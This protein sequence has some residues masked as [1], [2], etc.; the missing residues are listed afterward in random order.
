MSFFGDAWDWVTGSSLSAN[1]AKTAALGYATR[2]LNDTTD[3]S[4]NDTSASSQGVVEDNGAR[5]QLNPDTQNKLPILYGEAYF[6]GYLTDAELSPDYKKM[7]YC[8]SLAELTGNKLDGSPSSYTFKN[9]YL[10]NNRVVFKPDGITVDL[11]ID[12]AGNEDISLRDLVKIYFYADTPLQP[13]GYSGSTPPSPSIM[14]GWTA[15]DNAMTGVMYAIIEV[16]Y[17]RDKNIVGLPNCLWHIDNSLTLPGD[18][19]NDYM[20]STVYGAGILPEEIDDSLI[21]LNAYG[22]AGFSFTDP[23]GAGQ[24]GPIDINGLINTNTNVLRNMQALVKCV[25]SWIGYDIHAGK[26]SVTINK[27]GTSIAS[28]DDSNIVDDINVS[29]TSL[30][31][32]YSATD[33]KYQNTDIK[34]KT[35][36]VK[37]DMPPAD[38]YQNE[39]G[40]RQQITL[41]Y[42]NKQS[43]ALK[44][45]LLQLKQSRIDK[46]ITFNSDYSY[47][48]L[49]AGQIID[50]T[51]ST[52]GYTN[53][54]FRI[55]TT[56]EVDGE[57]GQIE[58][59]F[60]CL[61]YND[62]VYDYDIQEYQIETDDGLLSIGS[63]GKPDAPLI[64]NNFK[65]V[66]PHILIT[67]K[68][69]S[70]VVDKMWFWVTRDT[71][72]ANDKDRIY[73]RI[74]SKIDTINPTFDE[75]ELV[76]LKYST[77]NTSDMYVK[78]SGSNSVVDGPLSDPSGLIQYIPQQVADTVSDVPV[79]MGDGIL[80]Q[81]GLLGLLKLI[82]YMMRGDQDP[83]G[84]GG[85]WDRIF[86]LF[87]D[88]TGVDIVQEAKDGNIG[89]PPGPHDL[90]SHTDVSTAGATPGDVLTYNGSTWIPDDSCCEGGG[91][92]PPPAEC[93]QLVAT[94]P[95]DDDTDATCI[96]NYSMSFSNVTEALL[97]GTGNVS[98]YKSDGT[99]VEAIPASGL[100]INGSTVDIP[101]AD[102]DQCTDYYILVDDC[103]ITNSMGCCSEAILLPTIWNFTTC[104][105]SNEDPGGP[106]PGP[107]PD[108]ITS[109]CA[110]G[111]DDDADRNAEL[112]S[113]GEG[114]PKCLE[115][116]K[117]CLEAWDEIYEPVMH[118]NYPVTATSG[119][120]ALLID[121]ST[122]KVL[123]ELGP[124]QVDQNC[125][126]RV[127][128]KLPVCVPDVNYEIKL[129]AGFVTN[130]AGDPS[131]EEIFPYNQPQSFGPSPVYEDDYL[132]NTPINDTTDPL[133]MEMT[134]NLLL[135]QG[136]MR[137]F[138]VGMDD[139]PDTLVQTVPASQAII[140]NENLI[141]I[142]TD[143][144]T[145]EE[146]VSLLTNIH[147][148]YN[149]PI[150]KNV[151]KYYLYKSPSNTSTGPGQLIQSFDVNTSF[152]ADMTSGI[153]SVGGNTVTLN[154]TVCL[155]YDSRYYIL[156]D[157]AAVISTCGRVWGGETSPVRHYFFTGFG[158]NMDSSN[159]EPA[160]E[161]NDIPTTIN[162]TGITMEFELGIQEGPGKTYIYKSDGTKVAEYEATDPAVTITNEEE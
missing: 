40:S 1:L 36:F 49:K 7:T 27:Q 70:G 152:E 144:Y 126:T 119:T 129:P 98:L 25:S 125:A 57:S 101:Y 9:V 53:K 82:D 92:P 109:F 121:S 16:I 99:F 72:I 151:G 143:P 124:A 132:D 104:V 50:I 102:R 87:E 142:D 90:N 141:V 115:S 133:E 80:G 29:G 59:E 112:C 140:S 56:S 39:P 116:T 88:D 117:D 122:G 150:E 157:V 46:V 146:N 63:I 103:V 95:P 51:S 138:R 52:Y 69:P 67:G 105:I 161:T 74:G 5:L 100:I 26:W 23:G 37:I 11:T 107:D 83:T 61:E 106:G 79:D 71:G 22:S 137:I 75:N 12:D 108:K 48:N 84:N 111:L 4:D 94:Y 68:V 15:G 127:Y 97:P 65:D 149:A 31:Q 30:T 28:L 93:F 19:L 20:Q 160:Q 77:T 130:S 38:L 156:G 86:D 153:I 21:E 113:T 43:V 58:I 35:D 148:N 47:M 155:E 10:N 131:A 91:G 6:G 41:P 78:V 18:A 45:G 96:G 128:I 120:Q 55:I 32:L 14:P 118:Y 135:G 123:Q 162:N 3:E 76:T 42:S 114:N 24:S 2:L 136:D 81:L 159:Y 60:T 147:L 44:V 110:L 73:D 89:G 134:E 158:S 33:V 34:D 8:L 13:E 145:A 62:S 85:L 17:N 154:P 64:D 139:E 66:D 54:P